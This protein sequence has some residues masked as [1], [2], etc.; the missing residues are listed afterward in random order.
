MDNMLV[1][2]DYSF[3]YLDDVLVASP[4]HQTHASHLREVLSRFKQHGLVLNGEKCQLGVSSLD[5]LGHHVSESGIRPIADRVEAIRK[6]PQPRTV[7]QLQTYLGMVNFYRRFLPSAARVLKPLTDALQGSP[8]GQLNFSKEMEDAYQQSKQALYNAAELAHPDPEAEISLAVDASETHVGAVLQQET[9]GRGLRPLAFFSAKL[10]Q[11]QRKYSAYDREL[12]A[13]YL[14]IRHFR[15]IL[16]GRVFH[17]WSDHKPLSFAMHKAAEPWTARQQRHISYVSEFTT[18]IRHVAGKENVV[19]DCLSRPPEPLSSH[20]STHVASIKAPSGSLAT[21]DVED[22]SGGASTSVAVVAPS[23]WGRLDFNSIAEQQEECGQTQKLIH[24][25]SIQAKKVL[26]DGLALWCDIAT[27]V[28]RP[29]VPVQQRNKIFHMMHGLSHPGI[30]ATKRLISSRFVWDGC[31]ADV[32]LWCRNCQDCARGKVTV[33]E[34]TE[35]AQIPVP[36]AR[37]SHV[38]VDLVGPLPPSKEGYTHVLTVVD[39][40]TRWPEVYPVRDLTATECADTF[41]AGW[42]ACFGVPH[43]ITSDRGTQFT[44]AVWQSMCN[45]L[46]VRHVTT[47]AYHPQS[48]GMVER[49]HRQLKDALRARNCGTAWLE[50]LPWVLLGL[51]ATPKEESGLSS[52]EAVYGVPLVLPGQAQKT[53]EEADLIRAPLAPPVIPPRGQRQD[54]SILKDSTFVYVRCG[55]AGYPLSQKYSG[56]YRILERSAKIYKLQIGDRVETVSADRLKPHKGDEPEPAVPPRRGRPPIVSSSPPTG[57]DLEGGPVE[58]Q[59]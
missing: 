14:A 15:W 28:L 56:P 54:T 27:G 32:A 33:Q 6:F 51:R 4:D 12:L 16:E 47:T 48:N 58:D 13:M 53:P 55:P 41:T 3:I 39:R 42:V 1:G 37:F 52:A 43:T 24:N 46:G 49:F 45:T 50:H 20:R 30:R 5:Y 17:V 36:A 25:P 9:R 22:S 18:D 29:L 19:A 23:T 7:A 11:A 2:L 34:K 38:H 31:A 44:S 59:K 10:D 57:E 35:P 21:P 8:K 40:S 26:V